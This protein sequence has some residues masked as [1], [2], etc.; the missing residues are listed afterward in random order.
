ME[1]RTTTESFTHIVIER[2][3][4][5]IELFGSSFE[6]LVAPQPNG[7]ATCVLKGTIPPGV[8]VPIHRHPSIEACSVLSENV[9]LLT[10]EGGENHRIA[11]SPGDFMEISSAL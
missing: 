5:A 8:S 9:E 3:R 11:A 6:F 4:A 7:E 2:D 10:D 1:I